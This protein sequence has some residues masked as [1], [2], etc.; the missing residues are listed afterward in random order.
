MRASA[1][2]SA[3]LASS[4]SARPARPHSSAA[5]APKGRLNWASTTDA[6]RRLVAAGSATMSTATDGMPITTDS[7]SS[8]LRP[9]AALMAS[10]ASMAPWL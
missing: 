2:G 4:Y 9:C 5:A 7:T 8:A 3:S 6:G 1:A 10:S